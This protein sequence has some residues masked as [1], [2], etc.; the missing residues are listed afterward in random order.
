MLRFIVRRIQLPV[1]LLLAEHD[2]IIDNARTRA[3]VERVFVG[4]REI[5]E[6]AGAHHTLEFEPDPEPFLAD[7]LSW[8]ERQL[9]RGKPSPAHLPPAV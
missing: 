4:D 8:L 7:L 1:L 9:D 3:F 5:H 2:R 6:Y